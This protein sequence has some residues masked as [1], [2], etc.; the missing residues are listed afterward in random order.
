MS[1]PDA[2]KPR[3]YVVSASRAD[4]SEYYNRQAHIELLDRLT[5]S[6]FPFHDARGKYNGVVEDCAVVVGREAGPLVR[7]LA[8][9]FGQD[10]FLVVSENDRQAYTV[11]PCSDYYSHVGTLEYVGYGVHARPVSGP[12]TCVS[13]H[14]YVATPRPGHYVDLPEGF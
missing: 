1:I 14:Y 7:E 3:A 13:G 10:S 11:D 6:G 12:W 2:T 9:Y 5:E 4:C 8:D